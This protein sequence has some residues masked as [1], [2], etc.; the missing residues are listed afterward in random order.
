MGNPRKSIGLTKGADA[1]FLR[2]GAAKFSMLAGATSLYNVLDY[3][4]GCLPV[5]HV[6]PSLDQL[7][8]EWKTGPGLGS[9][10][11]EAGLYTGSNA[12]YNPSESA[13]MPIN[14]QIAG[15]KWEEEKVLAMMY[16]IDQALGKDRGFG[17]GSWNHKVKTNGLSS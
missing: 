10:I 13:G 2:S 5:T 14:I 12:L 9:P 4:V 8:E 6:D 1:F 17:P 11:V 16:V 7:T 3:P 15:R